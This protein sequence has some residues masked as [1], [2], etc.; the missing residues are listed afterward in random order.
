MIGRNW[1]KDNTSWTIPVNLEP[2]KEYQIFITTNFRTE[3]NIPLK[4]YLIE[5]KTSK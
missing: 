1:G 3:E 5:F 4:S 2:N